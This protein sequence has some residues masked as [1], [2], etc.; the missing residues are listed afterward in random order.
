MATDGDRSYVCEARVT[1]ADGAG[2]TV[3]VVAPVRAA[4]PSVSAGIP[5]RPAALRVA[6][7]R[8]ERRL[9]ERAFQH[10]GV[11]DYVVRNPF[12]SPPG[13]IPVPG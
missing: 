5:V 12:A 9:A 4:G 11:Y 8:A 13:W 6:R 2:F 7:E 3:R 10:G 1:A